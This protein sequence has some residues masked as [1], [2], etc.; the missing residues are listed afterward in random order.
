MTDWI[1]LIAAFVTGGCAIAVVYWQIRFNANRT[2]GALRDYSETLRTSQLLR[3]AVARPAEG[4][5]LYHVVFDKYF[6]ISRDEKDPSTCFVSRGLAV[7]VWREDHYYI[8]LGY[9]NSHKNGSSFATAV[10]EGE[11]RTS[12]DGLLRPGDIISMR[13]IHR[14]GKDEIAAGGSTVDASRPP[15]ETYQYRVSDATMDDKGAIASFT[16]KF[17]N[18]WTLVGEIDFTRVF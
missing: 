5:W 10:N 2:I 7:V 17:G 4:K 1:P 12:A 16:C 18:D 9:S 11:I 8:M 14:L 15:E 3:K 6:D 13:Y